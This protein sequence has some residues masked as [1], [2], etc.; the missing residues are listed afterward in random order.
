MDYLN[1]CGNI[2]SLLSCYADCKN[3]VEKVC[4][5]MKK[6]EQPPLIHEETKKIKFLGTTVV[7][8]NSVEENIS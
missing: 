8:L 4:P 2:C 7:E 5:C 1:C 6:R 3:F